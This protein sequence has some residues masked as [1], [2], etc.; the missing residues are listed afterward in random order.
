VRAEFTY[1][2][3]GANFHSNIQTGYYISTNDIIST[4]DRRIGSAFFNLSRDNVL[5]T[6]VDLV[7]PSDLTPNTKYW[8][9]VIIDENNAIAEAVESNNA[10]YIPVHT[11][12]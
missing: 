11:S 5:T 6:T 4:L 7:I 3:N 10:T 8:L 12:P 2:N 9:G 1:E